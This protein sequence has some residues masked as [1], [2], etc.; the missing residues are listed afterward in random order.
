MYMYEYTIYT[1]RYIYRMYLYQLYKHYSVS[2]VGQKI[3]RLSRIYSD[4]H[5]V[6][7]LVGGLLER[8]LPGTL[9]TPS[10][11][12]VLAEAFHR[13]K[14]ADRYFYEFGDQAGSFTL[15][16]YLCTTYEYIYEY[17]RV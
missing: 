9:T 3:G 1:L 2:V 7:Y 8:R 15:G 16:E 11:H 13:Y 6:D 10:F 14:F 17:I 5:D 4:V 12:C